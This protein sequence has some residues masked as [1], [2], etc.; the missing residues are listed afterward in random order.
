MTPPAFRIGDQVE[1]I[2]PSAGGARIH[3]GDK[4]IIS[5]ILTRADDDAYSDADHSWYPASSLRLVEELKIGDL[6][7][8]VGQPCGLKRKP[9]GMMGKVLG[10][11]CE[12]NYELA[13]W[14]YPAAS[15]RKLTSGEA[16]QHVAPKLKLSQEAKDK[17]SELVSDAITGKN[18]IDIDKRLSAI[19]KR[20]D[21]SMCRMDAIMQVWARLDKRL[22]FL[23]AFQKDQHPTYMTYTYKPG[24]PGTITIRCACGRTHEIEATP[25]TYGGYLYD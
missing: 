25:R 7:E 4:F 10:I 21:E 20:L 6:V 16:K 22:D 5:E 13:N 8:I 3:V 23:E 11:T 9:V 17:I 14:I 1:I 18:T 12:G 2:G 24:E 15:L 19:E